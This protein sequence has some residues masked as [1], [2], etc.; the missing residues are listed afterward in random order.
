MGHFVISKLAKILGRGTTAF[1][2]HGNADP[3]ALAS[4]YAL[5]SAFS[6][7]IIATEG[8]DRMSKRLME[9]LSITVKEGLKPARYDRIVVLDTS[10]PEQLG[11][12]NYLGQSE[13]VIVI[14]HH[15]RS[16]SWSSN[17]YYCDESKSSCCE[18]VREIL[19]A[20][21]KKISRKVAL[22][23]LAGILTDSGHFKYGNAES[24]RTFSE[25][26]VEHKI[27]MHEVISLIESESEL[28]EKISQLKGAQ[29]LRYTKVGNFIIA[30][31]SGSAFESSVCRALIFLGANI[32]FV[33]SQRG[34]NFR[35]SARA[36]PNVVELGIHLGKML[37][38]IANETSNGGGGHPAA[39][40]LS[41]KGSVRHMLDLCVSRSRKALRPFVSDRK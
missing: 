1:V 31:S 36:S 10:G 5:S 30:T 35:I 23:L 40:G 34:E 14:D 3:D 27:P 8:L 2:M 4:A 7:A 17:S 12:F 6:G 33:G 26:M 41:G 18:I 29:R 28:S 39:A 25:I 22:A 37:E 13:D 11:R 9:R 20:A 16:S 32:A 38:G 19:N 21:G 15:A 24:L